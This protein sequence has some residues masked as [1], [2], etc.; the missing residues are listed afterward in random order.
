MKKIF[1]NICKE[2]AEKVI[3]NRQSLDVDDCGLAIMVLN[4]DDFHGDIDDFDICYPCALKNIAK[5]M[6][7]S[8]Y[9]DPPAER[10]KL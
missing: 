8:H 4:N 7:L 2:P 6:R 10:E 5:A 1:C 3:S 9:I